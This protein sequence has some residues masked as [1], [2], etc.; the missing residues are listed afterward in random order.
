MR[1]MHANI[2]TIIPGGPLNK[3]SMKA[4]RLAVLAAACLAQV[5]SATFPWPPQI[6]SSLTSNYVASLQSG[7]ESLVIHSNGTILCSFAYKDF[8]IPERSEIDL[9]STA[10][11]VWY[12]HSIA[13]FDKSEKHLVIRLEWGR[14]VVVDLA[15]RSP[16]LQVPPD[17]THEVDAAVRHT[18]VVWLT[19]SDSRER[20]NGARYAG[21]LKMR[22]TIPRL[23]EL[24]NDP[25]KGD[26][27]KGD[28]PWVKSYWV[29]KAAVNALK[30][31]DVVVKDVVL[32]EPKE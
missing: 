12:E 13:F 20:E 4:K 2:R 17:M 10:G 24:T 15:T 8:R 25:A 16:S 26:Y 29:R 28:A 14:Y 23:R 27:K 6:V 22:D 9:M 11:L 7:R 18:I 1:L 21:D 3:R 5:A 19:S 32:E 30:D 31:M